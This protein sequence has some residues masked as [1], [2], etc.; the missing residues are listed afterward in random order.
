M[1]RRPELVVVESWEFRRKSAFLL[2][3]KQTLSARAKQVI[4]FI[5]FAL[6]GPTVD[7]QGEFASPHG[8]R[9]ERT[10]SPTYSVYVG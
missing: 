8:A 9:E 2:F 1:D 5:V 10:K 6:Q 4:R 3:M 7:G